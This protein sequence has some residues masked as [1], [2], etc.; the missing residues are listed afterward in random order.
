M[1]DADCMKILNKQVYLSAPIRAIYI[2]I[3]QRHSSAAAP[4]IS[5]RQHTGF[6]YILLLPHTVRAAAARSSRA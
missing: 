4:P 5:Q 6:I 1:L 2:L 3:Y